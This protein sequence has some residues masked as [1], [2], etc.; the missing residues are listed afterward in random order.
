VVADLCEIVLT[1]QSK[2]SRG[3]SVRQLLKLPAIKTSLDN[4]H[5]RLSLCHSNIL[6]SLHIRVARCYQG[7]QALIHPAAIINS[8]KKVSEVTV[9][10]GQMTYIHTGRRVVW[11]PK[12]HVPA[13]LTARV[14]DLF[15]QR[16][17]DHGA[18]GTTWHAALLGFQ[19]L[20]AAEPWAGA[21]GWV[22]ALIHSQ[23]NSTTT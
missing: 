18:R 22:C 23:A 15:L 5:H 17:M 16:L 9:G 11:K 19:G 8:K 4:L 7:L 13:C 14:A 6:V 3:G 1:L 2:G 20:A 12:R 21:E 10:R